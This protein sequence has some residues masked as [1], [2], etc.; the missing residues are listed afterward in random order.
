[1]PNT[2]EA[3]T[4]VLISDSFSFRLIFETI[5]HSV[6]PIYFLYLKNNTQLPLCEIL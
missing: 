5:F 4:S 6:N 1:M 2:T 3:V